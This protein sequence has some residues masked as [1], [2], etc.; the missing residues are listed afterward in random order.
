VSKEWVLPLMLAVVGFLLG[1]I[2]STWQKK[3][4]TA[5][6][7]LVVLTVLAAA[8]AIAWYKS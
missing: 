5:T 4:R 6:I 7:V 1:G 2:Y 8:G 3:N